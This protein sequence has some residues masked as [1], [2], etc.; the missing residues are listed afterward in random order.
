[1]I[2][3]IPGSMCLNFPSPGGAVTNSQQFAFAGG[4]G[5]IALVPAN[6]NNAVCIAATGSVLDQ[7]ACD[8]TKASGNQVG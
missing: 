3:K 6:S 7:T 5:P 1:M 4:A 8:P 2:F